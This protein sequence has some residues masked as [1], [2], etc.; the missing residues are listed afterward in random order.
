[1]HIWRRTVADFILLMHG[2]AVSSDD[3]WAPYIARLR[4]G[5]HFDGGSA[6]GGGACFRKSGAA[7]AV[8]A[9]LTGYIKL[10]ADSLEQA[11][12]LLPG[13]PHYE[14]GGTVEIR[15]LPLTD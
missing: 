13:N 4:Q 1:M 14:A 7:V 2:D 9:H 5:G 15:E 11:R 6:I 8:T 12:S 10:T 3:A